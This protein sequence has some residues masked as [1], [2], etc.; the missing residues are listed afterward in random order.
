MVTVEIRSVKDNPF[1]C[2]FLRQFRFKGVSFYCRR[3]VSK[4]LL[5]S[6]CL[7][8]GNGL[9]VYKLSQTGFY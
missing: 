4:T 9:S 6:K 1:Y 5:C 7:P 3:S 2:Q 8:Y